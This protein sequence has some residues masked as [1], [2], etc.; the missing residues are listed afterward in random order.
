MINVIM[1]IIFCL[2]ILLCFIRIN[3]FDNLRSRF[4]IKI[5]NIFSKEEYNTYLVNIIVAILGVTISIIF[6][7]YNT[8][9]QEEKQTIEFLNEVVLKE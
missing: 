8:E 1:V 6:A 2:G 4:L 7:N 9:K 3:K 5:I